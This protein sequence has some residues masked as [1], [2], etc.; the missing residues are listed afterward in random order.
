VSPPDHRGEDGREPA[1]SLFF[2]LKALSLRYRP[3]PSRKSDQPAKEFAP[4]N[5]LDQPRRA[6]TVAHHP[7]GSDTPTNDISMTIA[8]AAEGAQAS[9]MTLVA[10]K[11][12]TIKTPPGWALEVSAR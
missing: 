2:A 12:K 5:K 9:R 7:P 10:L 3:Q 8:F 6:S 11:R 1:L 4:A